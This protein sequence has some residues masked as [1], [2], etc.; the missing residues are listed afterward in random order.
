M[1]LLQQH[2]YLV[3]LIT[4]VLE[5]NYLLQSDKS[6]FP[7]VNH[8][9]ALCCVSI[10][11]WILS[12]VLRILHIQVSKTLLKVKHILQKFFKAHII[13]TCHVYLF[14]TKASGSLSSH[15][16]DTSVGLPATGVSTILSVSETDGSWTNLI[17]WWV[18]SPEEVAPHPRMS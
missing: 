12:I 11:V 7:G 3:T 17:T 16:L 8:S 5:K 15:I 18:Q 14:Q 6:V 4:F 9:W 2:M 13:N 1:L 10:I